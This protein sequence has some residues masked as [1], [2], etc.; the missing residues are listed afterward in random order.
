MKTTLIKQVEPQFDMTTVTDKRGLI[1]TYFPEEMNIAEFNLVIT[2]AGEARGFHKHD[3]FDEYSLFVE[4][5]GVYEEYLPGLF[6][7]EEREEGKQYPHIHMTEGM[8][9]HIPKG[10]YHTFYAVTDV[11][12]VVFLT[13]RW[14]DCDKPIVR[15]N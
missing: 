1:L 15:M 5:I 10:C 11:K 9:I 3:E 8:C 13:K 4:G 12:M 7:F 6:T 14:Q 2:R